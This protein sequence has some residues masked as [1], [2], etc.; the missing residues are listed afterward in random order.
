MPKRKSGR[1]PGRF[2]REGVSV[3]DFFRAFP[4]EREAEDWFVVCRWPDGVR[5]P[6]CNGSNVY[7]PSGNSV[8]RFRCR[9]CR[10]YFSTRT[11]TVLESSKLG[12]QPWLFAM[13]L[14]HTNLKGVSSMKLHR[15]LT[16]TQKTAWH[17]AHRIRKTW[18]RE[19]PKM[20][21][22][23][24]VDETLLGG[25]EGNK[26]VKKKLPRDEQ[27]WDGRRPHGKVVVVGAKQRGSGRV[28]VSVVHGTDRK[29]LRGFIRDSVESGS[30]LY[31]DENAAYRGIPDYHHESVKHSAGQYVN[32]MASTNGIE[33]FWAMLKRG[34]IGVYHKMS[35]KHVH[36]YV[37]EFEGRHNARP[38]DTMDQLALMTHAI[39]GKRL[40]Y[41]DLVGRES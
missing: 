25:K 41:K 36:R 28:R 37:A 22:T 29:T 14:M 40:R 31:T 30:D 17:L 35:L 26:H 2:H 13:F 5:C 15:D 19:L 24:E 18:E 3:L 32:G 20:V 12:Y 38:M 21:G 39:T 6:K 23:V 8:Q 9:P 10:R 4:N 34:Y 33:S 1:A 11:G 27:V 16:V 7:E